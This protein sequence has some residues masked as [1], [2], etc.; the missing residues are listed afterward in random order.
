MLTDIANQKEA[1]RAH[2]W[3]IPCLIMGDPVFGV[4]R[5]KWW[6][7][8]ISDGEIPDGEIPELHFV[9]GG[10]RCVRG[11]L[12][13]IPKTR[14]GGNN[15]PPLS[16]DGARKHIED[17]ISQLGGN[18]EAMLY[19]IRWLHWG[20]G[21]SSSLVKVPESNYAPDWGDILYKNFQL[22]RMQSA[23]SDILGG[24]LADRHS[25][26]W[27]PNGF[28]PTP[29]NV[30]E[31]MAKI[32]MGDISKIDHPGD[33]RLQSV[34]DPCVGTGRMLLAA[35]GQSLNLYGMDIDRTM[36]ESCS[37]NMALFSPW[38]VYMTEN[39]KAKM[40]VDNSYD[41]QVKTIR[42]MNDAR[43]SQGHADA[44]PPKKEILFDKHGQGS[45]F[46]VTAR[47]VKGENNEH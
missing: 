42:S 36:V 22:G 38:A 30:C 33:A 14:K 35:S 23:D 1:W 26:G 4:G 12:P 9:H 46:S 10:S 37:I 25:S 20:L 7:D 32:V 45:L 47:K 29:I 44:L 41:G 31:M 34:C 40:S 3:L 18:W 16:A 39:I 17:L 13:T 28:Y 15:G 21:L 6:L 11:G 2:G 5:V 19:F 24:I 27:N 43:I 8:G